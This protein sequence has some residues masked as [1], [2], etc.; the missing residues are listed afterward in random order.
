MRILWTKSAHVGSKVIRW[1]WGE[2]CSHVAVAFGPRV[3]ESRLQTGV[4][5]TRLKDFLA[6]NTIVHEWTLPFRPSEDAA[7]EVVIRAKQGCRYDAKA[8]LWWSVCALGR[9]AFG[10]GS[11]KHNQW[12]D[13][14]QYYC[15]EIL[16]GL[17]SMLGIP[18]VDLQMER[19]HTL[20]ALLSKE[21]V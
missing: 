12:G 13:R 21:G 5:E 2:D 1:G 17:E 11:T 18:D 3:Y 10:I 19:P 9:R 14:S 15:V 6:R 7:A 4:V 20:W 8:I 16:E